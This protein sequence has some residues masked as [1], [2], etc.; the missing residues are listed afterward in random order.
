MICVVINGTSIEEFRQK[1]LTLHPQVD[2]VELRLDT[3]QSLDIPAIKELQND[4]TLPMIFTLRNQRQGGNYLHSEGKRLKDLHRLAQ[5]NPEYLDIEYDVPSHTINE[6]HSQFP[7]I[8]IILSYHNFKETPQDLESIYLEMQRTPAHYYKIAVTPQNILDTLRL[9][10]WAKQAKNDLIAIGMGPY[11]Q[12]SRILGP[13]VGCPMTYAALQGD[14]NP[15]GQLSANTLIERYRHHSLSPGTSIYGLIGNPVEQSVSD[16]S[17][18]SYFGKENIDAVYVKFQVNPSELSDFLKLALQLPIQGLSV[19]MPLKEHLI[20]L[21]DHLDP[22]A[23]FVG[24]AN[25]LAFKDLK[26]FGTN[27]DGIG[28]LNAIE[29]K[30]P[31]KNK[32]IIIIGA[33][34]AAKGIAY[35][36][37]RRGGIVTVINR[38]KERAL[39]LAS[40]LNCRGEGL[41]HMKSCA[42][43]GYDILINCTPVSMPIDPEDILPNSIVM[44]ITTKP[45]E[46]EFLK[47]AKEKE[48]FIVYG[49]RM[50]VEQALRQFEYWF[51]NNFSNKSHLDNIVSSILIM[52]K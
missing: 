33:G 42:R 43:S 38:N 27:T 34:G 35:E 32:K 19:T 50:F 17:H 48:C 40:L 45:M 31:V 11:G 1:L 47:K 26:I 7:Q 21:I 12:S 49:Y 46:T 20:P 39:E 2:M 18:N 9:L 41:D 5:L 44:D 14:H 3:L 13:I 10:I 28:A 4:F 24:A 15:L 8:K 25:T 16:E 51:N 29:E 36:A 23:S 6:I 22:Q 37:Q 30:Y 52:D